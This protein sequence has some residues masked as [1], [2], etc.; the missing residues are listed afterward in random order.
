[1]HEFENISFRTNSSDF[2]YFTNIDEVLFTFISSL[3]SI[4]SLINICVFSNTNLKDPIYSYHLVS[5]IVDLVYS[6]IV[7]FFI[8]YKCGT[9]CDLVRGKAFS[10]QFYR[11]YLDDYF[12]SCLAIN[13]ILLELLASLQRFFMISNKTF[14]QSIKPKI[15]LP[16]IFTFSLV[17]YSPFL[18]M[19]KIVEKNINEFVIIKTEFGNSKLGD[20][21]TLI[22]ASLRLCIASPVLF[23]IN[24]VTLIRFKHRLNRKSNLTIKR[25]KQSTF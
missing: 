1:M 5:S 20:I 16:I 22:L 8:F 25:L 11:A 24:F 10:T 7:S 14:L 15:F 13:N 2:R 19:G 12:T 17:Y 21:I 18:F 9:S 3:A 6:I 23:I 4:T